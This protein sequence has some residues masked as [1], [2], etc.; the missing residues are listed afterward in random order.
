M[1]QIC[2]TVIFSSNSEA[3]D[4]CSYWKE[5]DA[6][7]NIRIDAETKIKSLI[8][9]RYKP[10]LSDFGDDYMKVYVPDTN[11]HYEWEVVSSSIE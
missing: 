8:K 4:V 10:V 9:E 3:L 7:T 5:S 6:R 11:I 2:Y 1:K